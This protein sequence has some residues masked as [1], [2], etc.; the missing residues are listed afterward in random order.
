MGKKLAL[1]L[2]VAGL[3]LAAALGFFFLTVNGGF[4]AN[5]YAARAADYLQRGDRERAAQALILALKADPA[6][7]ESRVQLAR[8]LREGDRTADAEQVLR[9]GIA[10]SGQSS[11]CWLELARLY[12]RQGRLEEASL[13]L[14]QPRDGYLSLTIG[15]RRPKLRLNRAGGTYGAPLRLTMAPESGTVYYYTLDGS[16]PGLSS[17]VWTGELELEPGDYTLTMVAVRGDLPSPILRARYTVTD[18]VPTF[19]LAGADTELLLQYLRAL[20]GLLAASG[21]PIG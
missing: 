3:L 19:S 5:Y 20:E 12:V 18:S 8:L 21:N 16:V 15:Q 6:R 2:G 13:L 14:D 10:L 1:G 7:T 4:S 9:E 11:A 17:P